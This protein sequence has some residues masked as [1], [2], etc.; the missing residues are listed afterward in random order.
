MSHQPSP[1]QE[2]LIAV[3]RLIRSNDREQ[4]RRVLGDLLAVDPDNLEAWGLLLRL[5]DNYHEEM[6]YLRQILSRSPELTW[7]QERLNQLTA[8]DAG[9]ETHPSWE[10]DKR[11]WMEVEA[12][13][14]PEERH[15]RFP[16]WPL[17]ALL[18]GFCLMAGVA[19]IFFVRANGDMQKSAVSCEDL[20][21]TALELSDESCNRIDGN[22]VCYGNIHLDAELN[23][24]APSSFDRAGDVVD[25]QNLLSLSASPMNLDSREWGIALFKL[26][27]NI[28]YTTPG[29]LA[30]FIVFG[31]TNLTNQSGDMQAFYFSSGFGKIVCESVPLDGIYVSM[32]EGSGIS[33]RVN[34]TDIQLFGE[35]WLEAQRG[36]MLRLSVI[37]G[38]GEVESQPVGAG[39]SVSVPLDDDLK[40][41]GP[42]SVPEWIVK[43]TLT[44][45]C[46][47]FKI[48]CDNLDPV[49]PGE[50]QGTVIAGSTSAAR[51]AEGVSGPTAT[52][53][54]GETR[55]PTDTPT[56]IPTVKPG[57][58][59]YTP[60][61]TPV[62]TV[63]PGDPTYTPTPTPV[64]TVKPGN[65]TY[66]PSPTPTRTPTPTA[67]PTQTL[68][69]TSNQ[70]LFKLI[71]SSGAGVA[72]GQPKYYKN[73]WHALP[74]TTGADGQ[75]LADLPL[76]VTGSTPLRMVY[77]DKA[78]DITQDITANPTVIFKTVNVTMRLQTSSGAPLDPGQGLFY[79]SGWR[80][81][82]TTSGGQVSKEL[83]PGDYSF[84]LRYLGAGQD[85]AQNVSS[86]PTITFQAGQVISDSG[87]CINFYTDGWK[88]FTDGMQLLAGSYS[89]RF[90]D[91]TADTVITI[92]GGTT[93]HIH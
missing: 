35:G 8:Y 87:T 17:I 16:L 42:P 24:G 26:E 80:T 68:I 6:V 73:G 82:G 27:A 29:Q 18:F 79:T 19:G 83:L 51:L 75:Y 49:Y 40:P 47:L 50:A 9:P 41:T 13:P 67:T 84:R 77:E 5:T 89:F 90:N 53:R 21:H 61:S 63:K 46:T 72:G 88:T 34:E 33:F 37:S 74:G 57:D 15:R 81:F 48:G 38:S 43:E 78:L 22:Q 44:Q 25:V 3:Y 31:D 14:A 30:T 23:P 11:E 60:T 45:S 10:D 59:T 85:I 65:P 20:I 28:A 12:Q 55:P 66:T 71:S 39:W 4:A 32:P 76:D 62:P 1:D 58:P 92:S 54:P 70:V 69:P 52:L 91:G 7:A 86:N 36:K 2:M 64:P 93:N 56:P